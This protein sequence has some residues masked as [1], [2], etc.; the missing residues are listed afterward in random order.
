[1]IAMKIAIDIGRKY[2]S[3]IDGACVG[4]GVGVVGAWSTANTETV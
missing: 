1:M 4:C 2:K 3:A